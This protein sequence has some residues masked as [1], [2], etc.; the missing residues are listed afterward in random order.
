MN[1]LTKDEL[2]RELAIARLKVLLYRRQV[3]S[4]MAGVMM[5]FVLAVVVGA[6]GV[7]TVM[8]NANQ[9]R[10]LYEVIKKQNENEKLQNPHAGM[11]TIAL[12][13]G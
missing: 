10:I 3:R 4:L 1:M 7:Y 2:V 11:L 5:A 9:T 13:N 6:W 8:N 12:K